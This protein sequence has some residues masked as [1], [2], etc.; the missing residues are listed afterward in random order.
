MKAYKVAFFLVIF[1]FPTNV[2]SEINLSA[3]DG[4]SN[5]Q[6]NQSVTYQVEINYT[7]TH[8]KPGS[9]PYLFK[10]ARLNDRQP[11][12]TLTQY[13][14][15]YQEAELL[16]NSITGYDSLIMGSNEDFQVALRCTGE[17]SPLR[18]ARMLTKSRNDVNNV[19]KKLEELDI[20]SL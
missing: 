13:C 6:V 11:N 8:T 12:S 9:Q 10:V 1:L 15:P 7:L 17:A 5:Y 20:V 3:V 19:L 2:R 14:P 16:Y 18:I 4:V